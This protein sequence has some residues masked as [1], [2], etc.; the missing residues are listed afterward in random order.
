MTT[1]TS[2]PARPEPHPATGGYDNWLPEELGFS[3]TTRVPLPTTA[4]TAVLS[5]AGL[6]RELRWAVETAMVETI[7]SESEL[8]TPCAD[9]LT[10][11][12]CTAWQRDREVFDYTAVTC[13]QILTGSDDELAALDCELTALVAEHNATAEN[14]VASVQIRRID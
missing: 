14:S 5:I 8:Y 9:P 7:S 13:R 4:R 12:W 2:V 3:G 11:E 10:A 1:P 6:P